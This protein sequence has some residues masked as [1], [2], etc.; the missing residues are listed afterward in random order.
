MGKVLIIDDDRCNTEMLCDMVS[1]G[2]YCYMPLPF[3]KSLRIAVTIPNYKP[4][5][6]PYYQVHYAGARR[7]Y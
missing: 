2:H 7:L 1:G 5:M 4:D 6:R 3:A